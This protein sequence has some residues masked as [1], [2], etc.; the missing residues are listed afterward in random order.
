MSNTVA[1]PSPNGTNFARL[2]ITTRA[3]ARLA[4]DASPM[5]AE[6]R[7][8]PSGND[9]KKWSGRDQDPLADALDA[10]Q[11]HLQNCIS[12]PND[13]AQAHQLLSTL[14]EKAMPDQG[15]GDADNPAETA[16]LD[17]DAQR[18]NPGLFQAGDRRGRMAGD[19]RPQE[20]KLAK[21]LAADTG[22]RR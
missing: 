11:E 10:M 9:G 8:K 2:F 18:R 1:A 3:P 15:G 12:D 21:I 6:Q 4:H 16:R 17:P 22:R 14:L 7:L 13:L 19:Q 20:S 5:N